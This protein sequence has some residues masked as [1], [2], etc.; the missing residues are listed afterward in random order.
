MLEDVE[1]EL[2]LSEDLNSV[3]LFLRSV[4]FGEF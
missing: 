3:W 2:I 1:V 4:F